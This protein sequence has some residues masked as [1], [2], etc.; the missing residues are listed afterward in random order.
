L[1]VFLFFQRKKKRL[2]VCELKLCLKDLFFVELYLFFV[3][4]YL[5]VNCF[6]GLFLFA[7]SIVLEKKLLSSEGRRRWENYQEFLT[8]LVFSLG[9][10][11]KK[12]LH[13]FF[14]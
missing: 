10:E 3:G 9:K 7:T 12:L 5:F 2:V 6:Q 13:F 1:C 4:L 8:G 11:N 14:L